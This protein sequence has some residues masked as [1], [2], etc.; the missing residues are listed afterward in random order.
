[1]MRARCH[2]RDLFALR[3]IGDGFG[4]TINAIIWGIHN[5]DAEVLTTRQLSLV[6]EVLNELRKKPLLHFDSAMKLVDQLE[7]SDLDTEPST[8][9]SFIEF[10][11]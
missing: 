1:M 3:E 11:A 5:K 8:L 4:A 9:D 7:D 10:D 2:L 6:I